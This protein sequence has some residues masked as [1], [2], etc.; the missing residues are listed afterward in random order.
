VAWSSYETQFGPVTLVGG[1]GGPRRVH[2]PR[3]APA[4]DSAMCQPG[5]QDSDT[6]GDNRDLHTDEERRSGETPAPSRSDGAG[7]A[8]T[9]Q[10]DGDRGL[11]LR[12]CE[13]PAAAG[14]CRPLNRRFRQAPALLQCRETRRRPHRRPR[15]RR[16]RKAAG[17]AAARRGSCDTPPFRLHPP[18]TC[19]SAAMVAPP[20]QRE[21]GSL[22]TRRRSGCRQAHR[23]LPQSRQSR[24][25]GISRQS[26]PP[27]TQSRY[28]SLART[29]CGRAQRLTPAFSSARF[30]CA[31]G[32]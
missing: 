30:S 1:D 8:V 12:H 5:C 7:L 6:R 25:I 17:L 3:H 19:A 18:A 29:R 27:S 10:R 31:T 28:A 4:L 2:F 26:P 9:C 21:P 23:R 22:A 15:C 24:S 14:A 11:V 16:R 13:G 20:G 32:S